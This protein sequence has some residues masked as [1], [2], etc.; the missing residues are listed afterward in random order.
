VKLSWTKPKEDGGDKVRGYVVEVKEKGS[1]K[2]KPL[3]DKAP[4]KDT[5]F[6]GMFHVLGH[7]CSVFLV[8]SA[9]QM[10]IFTVVN[11][12]ALYKMDCISQN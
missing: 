4:C 1:N 10:S 2:W 12:S 11:A 6:T 9:F 7:H 3:N 5:K 8:K